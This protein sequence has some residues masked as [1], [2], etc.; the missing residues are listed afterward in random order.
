[1]LSTKNYNNNSSITATTATFKKIKVDEATIDNYYNKTHIDD[2]Y[3]DKNYINTLSGSL[4]NN[5]YIKADVDTKIVSSYHLIMNR[6]ESSH[7]T[8]NQMNI[9]YYEKSYINSNNNNISDYMLHKKQQK[10]HPTQTTSRKHCAYILV[11][12][13]G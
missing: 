11:T 4:F 2:S 6:L 1:M 10:T 7:Y 13:P 9:L 12:P 5:Y 3:Y 8:I